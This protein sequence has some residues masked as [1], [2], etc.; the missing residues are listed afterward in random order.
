MGR[1][2]QI[3]L[4]L[5]E[6]QMEYI[7]EKRIKDVVKKHSQFIGYPINLMVQKEGEKELYSKVEEVEERNNIRE[8]EK[9][10]DEKAE[11]VMYDLTGY[12]DDF[13]NKK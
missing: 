4:Y 13:W 9:M 1:G 3:V 5:K 10:E 8:E 11:E 6:D 12:G 7:K 2:T